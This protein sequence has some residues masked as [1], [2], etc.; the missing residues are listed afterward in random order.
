MLGKYAHW[1]IALIGLVW[2]ALAFLY[3][4][5]V[6]LVVFSFNDSPVTTLPLSGFT[7]KW[8]E[9]FMSNGTM[10]RA[11]RNSITVATSATLLT[12][13]IGVPAALA[14]DRYDFLLKAVFTRTLLLPLTLPGI[15]TGIAMLNFYKHIGITPSLI[16]VVIGHAT[17][18]A[19]VVVTQVVARLQRLNKSI[20]EASADLGASP[21]QTFFLVTLPNIKTAILGSALL[22][23]TLSFDEIPV[24]F[25]LTGRENT[26]PM[27][28]Y[29][30]LRIGITPEINAVGTI[31][32]LISIVLIA[33]SVLMLKK[34]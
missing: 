18:L 8:Y 28:I 1:Q 3:V 30:T 21:M 4:P 31:I 11:L 33:T 23:F 14:I 17:A 5:I 12:L 2:L 34:E 13:L 26:L 27:Y 16:T 25:F 7:T 24:T 15:V 29:S 6:S 19:G 9:A 22:A 20:E 32:V 10:L